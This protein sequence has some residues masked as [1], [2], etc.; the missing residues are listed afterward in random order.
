MYIILESTEAN[1]RQIWRT[2]SFRKRRGTTKAYN[3]PP[4]ISFVLESKGLIEMIYIYYHYYYYGTQAME[5]NM[6]RKK[7]GDK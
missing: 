5:S 1:S 7:R 2:K 3:I 4:V 6:E